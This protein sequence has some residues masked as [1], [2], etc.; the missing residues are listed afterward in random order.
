[1][2]NKNE[3]LQQVKVENLLQQEVVLLR[4]NM[5]LKDKIKFHEEQEYKNLVKI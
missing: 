3:Q 4:K 1:M 2:G 5:S